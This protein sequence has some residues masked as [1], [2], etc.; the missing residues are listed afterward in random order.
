[1]PL[2][3]LQTSSFQE[4]GWAESQTQATLSTKELFCWPNLTSS[5]STMFTQLGGAH[6]LWKIGRERAEEDT[7]R[8]RYTYIH[9]YIHIHVHIN[10]FIHTGK[11]KTNLQRKHA[12]RQASSGDDQSR[13]VLHT[14]RER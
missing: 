11:E 6:A 9:T 13:S 8:E 7:L 5:T 3:A 10:I 4:Q 12:I 2:V 14:L 1:M